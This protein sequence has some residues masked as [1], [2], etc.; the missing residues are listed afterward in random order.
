MLGYPS[1]DRG[2]IT[3][4]RD[5]RVPGFNVAVECN[6]GC[7]IDA[8]FFDRHRFAEVVEMNGMLR[9]VVAV[10]QAMGSADAIEVWARGLGHGG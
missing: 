3:P 4:L 8:V 2:I 7:E 5:Q 9:P 1:D 6:D 10:A